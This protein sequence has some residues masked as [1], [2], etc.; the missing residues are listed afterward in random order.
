MRN[1]YEKFYPSF[2]CSF[3]WALWTKG[4]ESDLFY[5]TL[6]KHVSDFHQ[7]N[8]LDFCVINGDIIHDGKEFLVTAK[9]HLDKLPVKYYVTKGN[10]DMVSDAILE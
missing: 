5:E 7:N 6:V 2:C 3:R 8:T 4:T 9:K 10:H 1:S